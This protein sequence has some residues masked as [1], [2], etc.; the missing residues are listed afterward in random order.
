MEKESEM[1]WIQIYVRSSPT[2]KTLTLNVSASAT[3][4]TV[5]EIIQ[6]RQGIPPDT[7]RL[8]FSGQLLDDEKATLSSYNIKKEDTLQLSLGVRGD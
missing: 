1:E 5:K 2:G 8:V 7:Q 6:D 4:A 3:I